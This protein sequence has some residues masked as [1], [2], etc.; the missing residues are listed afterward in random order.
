MPIFVVFASPLG[1]SVFFFSQIPD[2]CHHDPVALD[3][4]LV[5]PRFELEVAFNSKHC[6]LGQDIERAGI[7]VFAPSLDDHKSGN[8]SPIPVHL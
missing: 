4:V 2:G 7:F 6:T 3:T 8:G 5:N 1:A